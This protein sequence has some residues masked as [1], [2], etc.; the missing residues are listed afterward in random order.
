MSTYASRYPVPWVGGKG[1]KGG[2]AGK[3]ERARTRAYSYRY[4]LYN[5][6]QMIYIHTAQ[7][8]ARRVHSSQKDWRMMDD[9]VGLLGLL[10]LDWIGWDWIG[11]GLGLGLGQDRR[12]TRDVFWFR[13]RT[14][15]FVWWWD[16]GGDVMGCVVMRWV[17]CVCDTS[18]SDETDLYFKYSTLLGRR[19]VMRYPRGPKSAYI[20]RGGCR[21]STL[22]CNHPK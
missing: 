21:E 8:E 19:H 1:G 10:G 3:K 17:V 16:C 7:S 12:R 18:A 14:A 22:Y 11:L 2:G 13:A 20:M 5:I 6:I 15:L 9:V 4:L